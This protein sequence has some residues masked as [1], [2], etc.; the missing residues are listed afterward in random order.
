MRFTV[1]MMKY[2]GN[3]N[4]FTDI[5]NN[6]SHSDPGSNIVLVIGSKVIFE[7]EI[8]VILWIYDSSFCEIKKDNNIKLVKL[9]DVTE[10]RWGDKS[11][12]TAVIWNLLWT[13]TLVKY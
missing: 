1:R 9:S 5:L 11:K 12:N 2:L 10:L 4:V 8:Y 3:I 7:S 13:S 6:G